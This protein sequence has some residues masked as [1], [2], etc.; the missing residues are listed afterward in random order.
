[1]EST[2]TLVHSSK[3]K[4]NPLLILPA[5]TMDENIEKISFRN[6]V[7]I[8]S[9]TY[10]TF[11][12]YRYPA[13]FIPHVVAYVLENYAKPKMKIFDP[14]A[15]YGTVGVISKLYGY[16]YEM[17]DINPMLKILHS[18]STMKPKS[19]DVDKVMKEL[20]NSKEQFIPDWDALDYW[21]PGEILSFLYKK[22]GYYH[23]LKDKNTKLILTIPLLKT[24]RYFSYDDS[25][26]QKLSKSKRSQEKI[27]KL[28]SSDWKSKF[29]IM[30]EKEI[31]NVI[32]GIE[33]YQNLNPKKTK[34]KVRTVD[35]LTSKLTEKKDIL[36]TSPPYLQSQEYMRQ[37]KLDLYWLNFSQKK[38][39]ELSKL[40]IPYR[41]VEPIEIK[42]KTYMKYRN[43]IKEPHI[44]KV[45][46]R[47]FWATLGSFTRLQ[48]NITKYMFIFVGHSSTRGQAI[49]IDRI[50]I[51]HLK[52]YGWVHEKTLSDTIVSRRLFAYKVNPASKINDPR[53][54]VE[55]LIILKRL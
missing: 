48:K 34:G 7:E 16:D 4:N 52:N 45:F 39:K 14:Y 11:G 46:D 1:M 17:W 21:F 29:Y 12:L 27:R 8:P 54:P 43:E 47:Y 55:N 28:L 22:W 44:Q 30:L 15:G 18:I 5:N 24:T 40:E 35:T 31:N 32:Q 19:I 3:T 37:A 42:S 6:M 53:T 26:R 36:I 33:E 10:A 20:Q 49:P 9:T 23:S 13:K 41:D 2:S 25:Q 50:F 51:E 38:I